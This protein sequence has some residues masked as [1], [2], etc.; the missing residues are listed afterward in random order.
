VTQTEPS[1]DQDVPVRTAPLQCFE[2]GR[3]V[4]PARDV[5]GGH[6]NFG[7]YLA[8]LSDAVQA[9]HD[10]MGTDE[11]DAS[12]GGPVMAHVELDYHDETFPPAT[13]VCRLTVVRVGRSSLE[14][15]VEIVDAAAP[16][17]PK[18]SGRAVHVWR[19][20]GSGSAG[21]PAALLAKCWR[22]R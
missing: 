20:P 7:A 12:A 2:W 14:H 13:L 6:V 9:W 8:Y 16:Q 3:A 19:I 18:A 5:V 22:G 21:W 11:R 1:L 4:E 15:R 10:A 17:A